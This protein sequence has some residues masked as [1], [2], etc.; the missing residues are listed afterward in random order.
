M[1]ELQPI[2]KAIILYTAVTV[3]EQ[4][5]DSSKDK[6]DSTNES[7]IIPGDSKNATDSAHRLLEAAS[8]YC[9]K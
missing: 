7:F 9:T 2:K 8:Q 6:S 4:L 5:L 3:I 1:N